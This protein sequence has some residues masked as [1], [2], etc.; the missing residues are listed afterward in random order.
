[1]EKNK[2]DQFKKCVMKKLTFCKIIL[3]YIKIVLFFAFI[4]WM[5]F[6]HDSTCFVISE[7]M[8]K[9]IG[10]FVPPCE[11]NLDKYRK[12]SKDYLPITVSGFNDIM[13]PTFARLDSIEMSLNL[14]SVEYGRYVAIMDSLLLIISGEREALI[15]TY[16]ER[17]MAAPQYQIDSL[18]SYLEGKDTTEMIRQGKLIELAKLEYIYAKKYAN[19]MENV[20]SQ[21]GLFVP[22]TLNEQFSKCQEH[23]IE[24][25]VEISRLQ[26]LRTEVVGEI[27]KLVNSFH[28]NRRDSVGF[29]D[30][31]YYSICVSTTVSFGD[32]APNNSCTR[33]FAVA[34]ILLCLILLGIIVGMV[35][36]RIKDV[37]E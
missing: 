3:S 1:M 20:V 28:H 12:D 24:L 21:Y 5:L 10:S 29:V 15:N 36:D 26:G 18:K 19:V 25:L 2:F 4:N 35:L 16:I 8:N 22:D 23:N 9:K 32:I 14:D 13:K 34:E 27:C 11:F 37:H 30:F 31:L 33:F 17:E 6:R 7:Q